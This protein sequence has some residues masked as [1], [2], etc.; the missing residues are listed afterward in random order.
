MA[1]IKLEKT[2]TGRLNIK[3][4]VLSIAAILL[5]S[6]LLQ[7]TAPYSQGVGLIWDTLFHFDSSN[8]QHLIT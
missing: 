4:A 6:S 7:I 3:A 5:I 2:V 1:T 8:Y